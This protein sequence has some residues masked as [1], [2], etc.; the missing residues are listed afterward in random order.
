M[1][2]AAI[3]A[4]IWLTG[5]AASLGA[6]HRLGSRNPG[7]A[8]ECFSGDS[9]LDLWLAAAWPVFLPCY[10]AYVMAAGR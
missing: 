4:A 7:T 3:C 6:M 5:A 2:W 9:M 1:I 8:G 10:V